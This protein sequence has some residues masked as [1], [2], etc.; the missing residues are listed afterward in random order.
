MP[1]RYFSMLRTQTAQNFGQQETNP[2]ADDPG[3]D[4]K[5]ASFEAIDLSDIL[6]GRV[7]AW[8]SSS[9]VAYSL[10]ASHAMLQCSRLTRKEFHYQ[11][12][13]RRV[14]FHLRLDHGTHVLTRSVHFFD[15]SFPH[16]RSIIVL[17]PYS[18]PF[19]EGIITPLM[20]WL[21][22]LLQAHGHRAAQAN[23]SWSHPNWWLANGKSFH[24]LRL[25]REIRDEIYVASCGLVIRPN[26][27]E[28]PIETCDIRDTT[29]LLANK[30]V[31]TEARQ[32][33]ASRSIFYCDTSRAVYRLLKNPSQSWV[34]SIRHLELQ[35]EPFKYM[36][37]LNCTPD[38]IDSL[39]VS[40]THCN[41]VERSNFNRCL[42]LSVGLNHFNRGT[43]LPQLRKL[44][45]A[46]LVLTFSPSCT[47]YMYQGDWSQSAMQAHNTA[48]VL[49]LLHHA[50]PLLA[51]QPITLNG[52]LTHAAKHYLESCFREA[53][54]IRYADDRLRESLGLPIG[55]GADFEDVEDGGVRLPGIVVA[56]RQAMS[57][58][59]PKLD[60]S[61]AFGDGLRASDYDSDL[62][63]GH[64]DD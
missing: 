52:D 49:A 15:P 5:P 13:V 60:F 36:S 53:H 29:I 62:L 19:R 41:S 12:A 28:K 2:G 56:H 22:D 64:S 23:L 1:S 25:P 3:S 31:Y 20:K 37:L 47:D 32:A 35:M 21:N 18:E 33:V 50:W 63:P 42:K 58:F 24:L 38:D 26:P 4:V 51:G 6:N 48:F 11:V 27:R 57:H 7:R 39:M 17:E 10:G 43:S 55:D 8:R 40:G 54:K 16:S 9:L 45:L 14:D 61:I 46:S 59:R 44:R 30:Q 34:L